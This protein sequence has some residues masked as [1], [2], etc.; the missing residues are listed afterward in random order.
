MAKQGAI[1]PRRG[2]NLFMLRWRLGR[3]GLTMPSDARALCFSLRST[4]ELF[5]V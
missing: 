4:P 5:R 1:L 2:L 3:V